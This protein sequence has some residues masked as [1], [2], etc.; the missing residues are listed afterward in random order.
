[1]PKFRQIAMG[2]VEATQITEGSINNIDALCAET[3][4]MENI[5]GEVGDWIVTQGTQIQIL[6][7]EEF[8]TLY[9]PVDKVIP[10]IRPTDLNDGDDNPQPWE[11]WNKA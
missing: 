4:Q 6:T 11:E 10:P 2:V 1:M 3:G 9:H 7:D 8:K 5:K